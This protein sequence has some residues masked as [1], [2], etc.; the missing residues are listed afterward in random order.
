LDPI[1][2]LYAVA[3]IEGSRIDFAIIP[4]WAARLRNNYQRLAWRNGTAQD[5]VALIAIH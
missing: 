2:Y 3:T 1:A 5:C 4:D